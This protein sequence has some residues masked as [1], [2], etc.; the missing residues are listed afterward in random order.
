L[1]G[2]QEKKSRLLASCCCYGRFCHYAKFVQEL[3]SD[4]DSC[5]QTEEHLSLQTLSQP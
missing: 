4:S 1:E 3:L 5:I 2:I